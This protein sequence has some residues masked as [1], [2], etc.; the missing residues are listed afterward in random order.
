M[1]LL[2]LLAQYYPEEDRQ[3]LY[4]AILCGEVE[5]D[6]GVVKNP[7]CEVKKN[8]C[9]KRLGQRYVSRGALKLER[10]LELWDFPV[11]GE[12]FIDA[13]CSTGGFTEVLLKRGAAKV[14]AVDVGYNQLA[15]SLRQ[16]PQV[17]V[18]EKTNIMALQR[19]NLPLVPKSAVADISFRSILE[20]AK[21]LF[22]LI[23]GD[24]MVVLLKPQFEWKNPPSRFNGVVERRED[25]LEILKE[26]FQEFCQIG[27]HLKALAPSPIKGSK[28]NWEFLL[29]L[30]RSQGEISPYEMAANLITEK[31]IL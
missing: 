17:V 4:S 13:G 20:P 29:R 8:A 25:L 24:E 15:Y 30:H 16:N 9:V 27:L 26:F 1:K 18:M 10:A 2:D 31:N 11:K 28:G 22:S 6:G 23:S 14:Y 7:K 21:H 5:V 19:E 12:V 3:Q